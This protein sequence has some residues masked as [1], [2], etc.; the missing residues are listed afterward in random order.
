[1][2]GQVRRGAML[3]LAVLAALPASAAD[4]REPVRAG[5]VRF[6]PSEYA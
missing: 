5:H 3:A 6:R 4:L 2:P 1:M